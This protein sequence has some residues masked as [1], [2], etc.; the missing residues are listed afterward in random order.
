MEPFFFGRSTHLFG[1]FHPNLSASSRGAV[2]IAPPL[3]NESMRSHF[4]LRE[5][6]HGLARTG[7]DVLRF[8][9]SA[10]GDAY[11]ELTNLHVE[12]WIE[13]FR[14][15]ATEL[16]DL[17]GSQRISVFSSR[18]SSGL[19]AAVSTNTPWELAV[20][21]DPIMCGQDWIK[22]LELVK[23][24]Q[25]NSHLADTY[26]YLGAQGNVV[27]TESVSSFT[28][29]DIAARR[30]VAI[31]TNENVPINSEWE[32]RIEPDEKGWNDSLVENL[33][34]HHIIADVIAIFTE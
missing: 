22:Q 9:F 26:E 11:G 31:V 33:F 16:K 7:Y 24:H 17:T 5:I 23:S 28:D 21:W 6:S 4:A 19:A 20:M 10:C 27:F 13:D 34:S 14:D 12:D 25:E 2:V 8:D 15:A 1:V 3:L 29:S 18:F 30:I 32:C